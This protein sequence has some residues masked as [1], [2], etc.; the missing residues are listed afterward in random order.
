MRGTVMLMT[1]LTLALLS[2][3]AQAQPVGGNGTAALGG[4]VQGVAGIGAQGTGSVQS[5]LNASS[6]LDRVHGPASRLKH[7]IAAKAET[8]ADTAKGTATGTAAK[9]METANVTGGS[10]ESSVE[11]Q[12]SP[13]A[14]SNTPDV[15]TPAVKASTTTGAS[16]ETKP[17]QPQ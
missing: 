7:E 15:K 8:A 14:D 12:A 5:S 10:T 6:T 11:R 16:V 3:G 9:A 17:A 1:G 2:S 13:T 4:T